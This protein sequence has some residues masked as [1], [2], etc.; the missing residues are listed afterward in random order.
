[1]CVR[2]RKLR[3]VMLAVRANSGSR[4]QVVDFVRLVHGRYRQHTAHSRAIIG[5]VVTDDKI[6][7]LGSHHKVLVMHLHRQ[8]ARNVWPNELEKFWD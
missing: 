8:L 3:S 7:M 5:E 4:V 2:G 1:M 6:G